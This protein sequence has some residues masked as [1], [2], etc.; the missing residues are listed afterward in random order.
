MLAFAQ[1]R[2]GYPIGFGHRSQHLRRFRAR[3]LPLG[4]GHGAGG[5]CARKHLHAFK[6]GPSPEEYLPAQLFPRRGQTNALRD[7]LAIGR[8]PRLGI[9]AKG[10][11]HPLRIKPGRC[12]A[13]PEGGKIAAPAIVGG[14]FADLRPH[15]VEHEV[16]AKLLEID[17]PIH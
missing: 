6:K 14:V 16:A 9:P 15:G 11:E 13:P 1:C 4:A 17:L 7:E 12:A 3:G 2:N 10:F 5:L 8:A